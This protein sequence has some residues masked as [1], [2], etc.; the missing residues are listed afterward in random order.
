MEGKKKKKRK[1]KLGKRVGEK[2]SSRLEM[3]DPVADPLVKEG[4]NQ[5]AASRIPARP[6]RPLTIIAHDARL[7]SPR[8]E[9]T[10]ETGT[11]GESQHPETSSTR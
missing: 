2:K 6:L 8:C 4:R 1:E 9:I 11:E 5:S 10:G 3:H 7:P